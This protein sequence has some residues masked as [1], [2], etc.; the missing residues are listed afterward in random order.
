MKHREI[1]LL[2]YINRHRVHNWTILENVS[3]YHTKNNLNTIDDKV[4]NGTFLVVYATKD[5]G[6]PF[7]YDAKNTS[8]YYELPIQKDFC[9]TGNATDKFYIYKLE[10]EED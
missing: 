4:L 3:D 6:S 10:E 8:P 1:K 5:E 2:N 7:Y 9:M